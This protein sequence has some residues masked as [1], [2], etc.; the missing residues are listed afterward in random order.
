MRLIA[1]IYIIVLFHFKIHLEKNVKNLEV[2]IWI[3]NYK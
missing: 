3:I 1:L 2:C